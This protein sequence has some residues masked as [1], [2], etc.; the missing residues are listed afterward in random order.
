MFDII[1]NVEK[2]SQPVQTTKSFL[3]RYR[4]L[5]LPGAKRFRRRTRLEQAVHEKAVNEG[6]VKQ[7][8]ARV[9]GYMKLCEELKKETNWAVRGE[10]V[11]WVGESDPLELIKKAEK[12][13]L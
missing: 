6:V 12:V 13:W 1:E 8:V 7:L 11:V 9:V 5:G 10:E 3:Q 2:P 4:A